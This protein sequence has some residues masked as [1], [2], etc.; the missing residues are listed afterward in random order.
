MK[1][2]IENANMVVISRQEY[3]DLLALQSNYRE[4]QSNYWELQSDYQYLQFQ[5]TE[6]KRMLFGVRSER[7]RHTEN[8]PRQ[9][10]LFAPEELPQAAEPVRET[11]SITCERTKAK[12]TKRPIRAALPEHLKR[13][14][15]VIEPEAIPEGAVKIGEV[16]TEV[17]EYKEAEVYVRAIIRPK[18]T[19]P[20]SE[21]AGCVVVA[22]LPSLPIP[23]SN[24]GA[25]LL[26]HICVS[27]FVDHLP[28]YRQI[29]IFKREKIPLAEAT[30]KG[31]YRQTCQLLEP[32]YDKL[33]VHIL[34]ND[35]LQIDE[36][37][38][39]VLSANKPGSTHR[40]YMWVIHAPV[41]H[42]VCFH[43][44]S[45]RAGK[46]V[47]DLLENYHGAIQTDAYVGYDQF[48]HREDIILL[49]CMA[50]ARR[51]FEHAKDNVPTLSRQALEFF[52]KLYAVEREARE[53]G[54][55][56]EQRHELRKKKSLS[57]LEQFKE[58]LEE[59][60]ERALPRSAIGE[61]VSYTLNIW[62]RLERYLLSGK[63][64]IDSNLIENQI[65]ALALGRR[66]YLFA[67]NHEAARRN[68]M[69]Y[70]FFACCKLT[71]VNPHIWLKDVLERELLPHLSIPHNTL[72]TDRIRLAN[73]DL[74]V[75]RLRLIPV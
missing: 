10:E 72:M 14:E 27:K 38:M 22:D 52:K 53:G 63:Y 56:I 31:W 28:F 5:L 3:N 37:P 18:Y 48:K 66:N 43:Y 47:Q 42:E 34:T 45:S 41:T 59:Q 29:Q 1:T 35:Y 36:S 4:L 69:M 46:I 75:F 55:T 6:L 23:K 20:G 8:D 2:G 57:V 32:L 21:G 51:R 26:S 7:S 49:S 58:W 74:G 17:L 73:S 39:P 40:G 33:Q 12:E 65:R 70:S 15:E 50:H 62:D 16:I 64:E 71:E 13:V 61:A 68:A 19:V 60:R 54:M 24:A 9:L 44:A 25:G 67:G 30:V 11:E